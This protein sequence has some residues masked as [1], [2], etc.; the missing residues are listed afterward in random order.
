MSSGQF[1][2]YSESGDLLNRGRLSIEQLKIFIQ[3]LRQSYIQRPP[4]AH[5]PPPSPPPP[6]SAP[7][8]RPNPWSIDFSI[9]SETSVSE[10]TSSTAP[11]YDPWRVNPEDSEGENNS[12]IPDSSPAQFLCSS[13]L[14]SVLARCQLVL[15]IL[16]APSGTW[17]QNYHDSLVRTLVPDLFLLP[18]GPVAHGNIAV[19]YLSRTRN[20][21]AKDDE[22][23][24]CYVIAEPPTGNGKRFVVT[25]GD[26]IGTVYFTKVAKRNDAIITTREDTIVR[27]LILA[28]QTHS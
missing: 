17:Y 2:S 16:S 8:P 3:M 23:P 28:L 27:K 19:R 18:R 1:H 15:R 22:I 9:E 12:D 13:K 26:D 11:P 14:S 7:E 20:I 4:R 5:T 24:M 25:C 21:G 6:Q 10:E